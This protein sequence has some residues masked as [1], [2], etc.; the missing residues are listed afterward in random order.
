MLFIRLVRE[1]VVL[2]AKNY[3]GF[4]ESTDYLEYN[5]LTESTDFRSHTEFLNPKL[6]VIYPFT[7]LIRC[8]QG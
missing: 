8:T 6:D 1:S 4:T 2:K 3:H 5:G 7:P